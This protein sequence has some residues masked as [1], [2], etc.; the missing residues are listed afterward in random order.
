MFYC[1]PSINRHL[2]LC[3]SFWLSNPTKVLNLWMN[4]KLKMGL[5]QASFV[6]SNVIWPHSFI[7]S[8]FAKWIFFIQHAQVHVL[9]LKQPLFKSGLIKLKPSRCIQNLIKSLRRAPWA[10]GYCSNIHLFLNKTNILDFWSRS[11]I[12]GVLGMIIWLACARKLRSWRG[13][14]SYFKSG[15]FWG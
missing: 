13:H 2:A 9:L 1:A 11:K 14:F 15:M 6:T 7:Q 3:S 4:G 8:C 5:L 10:A 12:S